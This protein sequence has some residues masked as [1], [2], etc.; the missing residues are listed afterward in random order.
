MRA[1]IPNRDTVAIWAVLRDSVTLADMRGA[2]GTHTADCPSCRG[3]GWKVLRS[4]RI[5]VIG[6]I[7]RGTA[8]TARRTC[9]DCGGTRHAVRA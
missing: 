4:R 7:V 9:L 3:Y 1:Y 8:E 6:T 2:R 5:L